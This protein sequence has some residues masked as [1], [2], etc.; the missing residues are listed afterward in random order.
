[1]RILLAILL[2]LAGAAEAAAQRVVFVVRHAERADS[3]GA[4]AGMMANDPGLSA[5]GQARAES[6]ARLL[7]DAKLSDIFITEYRRTA[8][9]AA[10]LARALRLEPARVKAAEVARLAQRIA[11]AAGN[12]LVV[13]HSNT[14]PE[15]LDA[16]GATERVSIAEQEF[17]NLFLVVQGGP[18][19]VLI[20]L[21][22]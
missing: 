10:P 5:A 14:V 3:G 17:D 11:A 13:G 8:E 6:L 15:L 22:Y 19:P 21:R 12:V 1:M 9:T 7:R 18:A 16:L 4:A 20:R 2:L